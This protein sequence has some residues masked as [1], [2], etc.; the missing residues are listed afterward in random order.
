MEN[1]SYT[2]QSYKYNTLVHI[3]DSCCAVLKN[4]NFKNISSS[5]GSKITETSTSYL[6]IKLYVC[7]AKDRHFFY[8][9]QPDKR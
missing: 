1:F 4:T 3:S 6:S 9:M 7:S 8:Y 2:I 5:I